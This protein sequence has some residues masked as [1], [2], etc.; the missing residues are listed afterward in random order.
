MARR[1]LDRGT[2]VIVAT[3][4]V[5]MGLVVGV[6]AVV[7]LTSGGGSSRE[8]ER[9]QPFFVGTSERVTKRINEGGPECYQDPRGGERSFCVDLDAGDNFVAYHVVP[10]GGST[11]CLVEWDRAGKRYEDKC[12][13][14][15]V[16]P[17]T[18][19]RFPV[20]TREINEKVSVFVDVRTTI[21]PPSG[22]TTTATAVS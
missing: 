15:P 14:T 13:D 1:K 22:S 10:P 4:G 21:P 3:A 2:R 19:A 7:V 16:D 18:L 8:P 9:Y 5:A 11:A 12:S 6:V 17:A 20:L